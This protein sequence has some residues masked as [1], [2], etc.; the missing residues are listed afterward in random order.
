VVIVD[1]NV[2]H[3]YWPTG[4]AIGQRLR[5]NFEP[6]DRWYTVIGV[7]PPVKQDDFLESGTKET[8]YFH[9]A[10]RPAFFGRLVLRTTLPPDTLTGPAKAAMTAL[11]PELALFDTQAYETILDRALGPKRTPM[12]LTLAFAAVALALAVIGVYGVLTWAVT[13]RFSELGIRVALGARTT[14]IVRM[15]LGQG[16]R[17]IAIGSALG[18]V[19]AAAIGRVLASQVRTVSA[20][21]PAALFGSVIVL[22]AA[23][24]LASWLP[25]RR[26]GNTDPMI[27]LRAD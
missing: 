5:S 19:G 20:F 12:V 15:V 2:A 13:Q 16:G 21:D 25:A 3:K 18:L 6:P 17:L 4:S 22:A 27:A 14:D 23:A 26:A 7:V 11:D 8:L 10:Q 9:Y 1:T 24:L